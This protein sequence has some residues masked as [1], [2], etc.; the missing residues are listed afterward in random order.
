MCGFF[1]QEPEEPKPNPQEKVEEKKTETPV[2]TPS[3]VETTEEL[4]TEAQLTILA[5]DHKMT[6]DELRAKLAKTMTETGT[7]ERGALAILKSELSGYERQTKQ[8]EFVARLIAIEGNRELTSKKDQHKYLA[9]SM[10]FIVLEE[11]KPALASM[12]LQDKNADLYKKFC[13][14]NGFPALDEVFKFTSGYFL[15]RDTKM[16][17]LT[18]GD[19]GKLDVVMLK[20]DDPIAK[21]IP[22]FQDI[23]KAKVQHLNQMSK[24]IGQNAVFSATISR[25]I[26]RQTGEYMGVEI[27]DGTVMKT[28][29]CFF[30]EPLLPAMDKHRLPTPVDVWLYGYVGQD[31]DGNPRLSPRGIYKPA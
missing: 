2:A 30:S 25:H 5:K 16:P 22:T 14:A 9:S 24:Y 28:M 29:A 13:F 23:A 18:V 12:W 15:D 17:R 6:V 3:T 27:S 19:D 7:K 21:V 1:E 4:S 20:K 31:Q 8:K 10:E 26:T 11:N